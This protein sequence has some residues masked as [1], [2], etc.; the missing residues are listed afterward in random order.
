MATRKQNEQRYDH[1]ENLPDG[2]RRYWY[3]VPG[4]VRGSAR[5][6]KIVDGNEVTV[7]FAQYIYDDEGNLTE[8]HQK[9][10]V[11]TDHQQVVNKDE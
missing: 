2:G 1:W 4:Q 9:Y 7:F 8:I 6:I 5:Y 11:D 10:P 3:D